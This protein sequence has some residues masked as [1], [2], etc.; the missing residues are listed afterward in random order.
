MK[1]PF[2]AKYSNL[3]VL[4]IYLIIII[5]FLYPLSVNPVKYIIH[6]RFFSIAYYLSCNISDY[7][8][9]CGSFPSW[10]TGIKYPVGGYITYAGMPQLFTAGLLSLFF[11]RLAAFNL[12][13]MLFIL[14][15]CFFSF[16]LA[17]YWIRNK[18]GAFITGL[19]SGLSPF[20][21]AILY[22]GHIEN[23]GV[24]FIP[25]FMLAVLKYLDERKI[26]FAFIAALL[27]DFIFLSSAYYTFGSVIFLMIVTADCFIKKGINKRNIKFTA[28]LYLILICLSLPCYVYYSHESHL[29]PSVLLGRPGV[30]IAGND[31]YPS[32]IVE[33]S[34]VSVIKYYFTI[35]KNYLYDRLN[36]FH[37]IHLY[38]LGWVTILFI[39][40]GV[41]IKY[42]SR[43]PLWYIALLIFVLVSFGRVLYFDK[44]TPLRITGE[45]PLYMPFFLFYKASPLFYKLKNLYRLTYMVYLFSGLIAAFVAG[46][47]IRDYKIINKILFVSLVSALLL[48]E[49]TLLLYRPLK[50]NITENCVPEIYKTMAAE[51]G[52]YGVIEFPEC[53]I[54]W[55]N[56]PS[57]LYYHTLHKKRISST[58]VGDYLRILPANPLIRNAIYLS[59]N[60]D[61]NFFM[62]SLM[63]KRGKDNAN[64]K[65]LE[66]IIL[67]SFSN[68]RVMASAIDALKQYRFRYFILHDNDY[69][70]KKSLETTKEY[71]K[72]YLREF[73]YYPLDGITV[74]A[75]Q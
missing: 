22:N 28:A 71:L 57:G 34:P 68:E 7:I 38:Y 5:V 26:Y 61:M 2:T 18:Y 37:S 24:S 29:D 49:H 62:D 4:L 1:Y 45:L 48:G 43:K 15:N 36:S 73:K 56:N 70:D 11:D 32:P 35:D 33:P 12:M 6:S 3:L 52:D 16:L 58:M 25:L 54:D 23:F 19:I 51:P 46:R 67:R 47:I 60:G 64:T 53:F 40:A 21:F 31:R 14:M 74:Y 44:N 69:S 39:V 27:F 75:I 10:V 63:L 9:T 30:T 66:D 72:K 8:K 59:I 41:F 42:D 20:I 13:Q 17:D 55:P 65:Y 50:L